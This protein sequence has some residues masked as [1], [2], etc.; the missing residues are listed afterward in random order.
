MK[1]TFVKE[2]AKQY[3]I[4]DHARFKEVLLILGLIGCISSVVDENGHI[5]SLML[6]FIIG[7]VLI[8]YKHGYV[9]SSLK[10]MKGEI[11]ERHDA[12][13]GF[14]R[15]KELFSTYFISELFN[16]GIALIVA[17]VLTAIVSIN[18]N[19]VIA[20]IQNPELLDNDITAQFVLGVIISVIIIFIVMVITSALTFA[21]PYLL[22]EYQ[23]KGSQALN[24][25]IRIMKRH[26]WDFVKMQFS[27]VGYILLIAIL[28]GLIEYMVKIISPY[29]A[30]IIATMISQIVAVYLFVPYY[31]MTKVLFFQEIIEKENILYK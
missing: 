10:M 22:E 1:M 23:I 15:W 18:L 21:M 2:K 25:S 30:T 7:L 6:S 12:Y 8:S 29:L 13:V 11:V 3:L 19:E 28:Y 4:E 27:F 14:K 24:T 31:E 20:G 26:I 5:L 9:V 16:G 17:F